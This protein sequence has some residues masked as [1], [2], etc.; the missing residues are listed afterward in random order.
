MFFNG[1]LSSSSYF[2]AP[3]RCR[4][5]TGTN[6]RQINRTTAFDRHRVKP[7][8]LSLANWHGFARI[9]AL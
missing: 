7:I 5:Q 1:F 3:A 2:R 9:S 4:D 8:I 6:F